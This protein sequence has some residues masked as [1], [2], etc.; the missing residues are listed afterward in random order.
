MKP[1][2][3]CPT[4]QKP[5]KPKRMFCSRACAT[6]HLNRVRAAQPWKERRQTTCGKGRIGA[7]EV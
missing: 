3:Y 2:T 5:K 6:D 4:C 7:Y 1:E